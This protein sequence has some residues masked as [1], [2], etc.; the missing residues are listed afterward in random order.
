MMRY[1]ITVCC[2]TINNDILVCDND[3]CDCTNCGEPCV[4]SEAL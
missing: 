4:G 1:I 3:V 2:E